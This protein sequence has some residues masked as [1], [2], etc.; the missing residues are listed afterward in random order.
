MQRHQEEH[1]LALWSTV[2][3]KEKLVFVQ[4]FSSSLHYES[5]NPFMLLFAVWVLIS[6]FHIYFQPSW[7][8][9]Y[10]LL[11]HLPVG[12]GF[13]WRPQFC[14]VHRYGVSL[15]PLVMIC[16]SHLKRP[17]ISGNSKGKG[18][19]EQICI[20]DPICWQ[21]KTPILLEWCLN[22]E[23][24]TCTGTYWI[25]PLGWDPHLSRHWMAKW[26]MPTMLNQ[27]TCPVVF[28]W[29]KACFWDCQLRRLLFAQHRVMAKIAI[30]PMFIAMGQPP[31]CN[32][33]TMSS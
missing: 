4:P 28:T 6:S 16:W 3:W 9:D 1:K 31:W 33:L 25:A 30:I 14:R 2:F 11:H 10:L 5:F 29:H 15:P 24:F 17:R 20:V 13:W 32:H 22:L 18:G 12:S 8:L 7:L 27:V 19:L 23:S 21:V 26:Q